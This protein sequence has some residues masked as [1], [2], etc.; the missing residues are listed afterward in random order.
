MDVIPK[1]NGAVAAL[2]SPHAFNQKYFSKPG[3][4]GFKACDERLI[5]WAG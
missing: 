1:C 5:T 3:R 2:Q 4:G